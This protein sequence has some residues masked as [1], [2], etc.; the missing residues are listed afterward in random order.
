MDA[1]VDRDAQLCEA[2]WAGDVDGARAALL[3][4]ADVNCYEQSGNTPLHLAIEQ[5][6][7]EIVELLLEF[8]AN[9][10]QKT[11]SG[12]WTPLVHAAEICSV[13]AINLR[14]PP[15]NRLVRL[16]LEHGADK[17]SRGAQGQD[18]VE[19]ARSHLN[20]EAVKM[21]DTFVKGNDV[22]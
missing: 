7:V 15:D 2:V 9:V 6:F 19:M 17:R 8:G 12:W 14:R 10:N 16:L 22:R 3:L 5:E 18:A 21:L 1:D 11:R 20:N 4:G 13:A